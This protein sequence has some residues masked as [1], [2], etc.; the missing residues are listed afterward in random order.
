MPP[1]VPGNQSLQALAANLAK[2][3]LIEGPR[4]AVSLENLPDGVV[5]DLQELRHGQ[6]AIRSRNPRKL[7]R[8]PQIGF[9]PQEHM[10]VERLEEPCHPRWHDDGPNALSKASGSNAAAEVDPASVQ[11][12]HRL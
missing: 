7:V 1:D 3:I 2:A 8:C 9:V 10:R 4:P 12:E 5:D 11:Y 6:L